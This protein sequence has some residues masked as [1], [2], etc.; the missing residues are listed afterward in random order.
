MNTV[1]HE[2]KDGPWSS[3]FLSWALHPLEYAWSTARVASV[4]YQ[5]VLGLRTMGRGRTLICHD[6]GY[7]QNVEATSDQV[8]AGGGWG[9]KRSLHGWGGGIGRG[10][11]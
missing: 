5:L 8:P 6:L 3:G 4:L 2:R 1:N 11:T 7:F 10:L 9:W